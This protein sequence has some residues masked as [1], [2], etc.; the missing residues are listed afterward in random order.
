MSAQVRG[1][2]N[3]S[4]QSDASVDEVSPRRCLEKWLQFESAT[5]S[6][7]DLRQECEVLTHNLCLRSLRSGSGDYL[8][9][10]DCALHCL[11]SGGTLP[12]EYI[13]ALRSTISCWKRSGVI[14]AYSEGT[15]TPSSLLELYNTVCTVLQQMGHPQ[16]AQLISH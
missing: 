12:E 3:V 6:D 9:T 2:S 13:V 15:P 8:E 5:L 4:F 11:L 16:A 10:I 14:P 7:E 1:N